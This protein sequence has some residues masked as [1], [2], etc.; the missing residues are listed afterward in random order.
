[1]EPPD[2]QLAWLVALVTAAGGL[3]TMS[4][5][6]KN[7]LLWRRRRACPGCGRPVEHGRCG[8]NER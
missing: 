1:M 8:C 5:V 6:S 7:L 3:M 4:G 2:P